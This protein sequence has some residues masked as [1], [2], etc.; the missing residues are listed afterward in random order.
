MLTLVYIPLS[1][2]RCNEEDLCRVAARYGTIISTHLG[3]STGYNRDRTV[4]S[5]ASD[6]SCRYVL[7]FNADSRAQLQ[8]DRYALVM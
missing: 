3:K 6:A 7:S 8:W 1:D 5:S 2:L 4:H